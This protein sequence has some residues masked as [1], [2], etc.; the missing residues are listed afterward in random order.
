MQQRI[1]TAKVEWKRFSG[2]VSDL[3][4]R[5]G[6]AAAGKHVALMAGAHITLPV[7]ARRRS[8]ERF[9][10]AG[11]SLPYEF[12]RYNNSFLNERSVEIP[13]ARWFLAQVEAGRVLE[14]GNVLSHYGVRGHDV[15][16]R[17]ETIEGVMNYDIV[18]YTPDVPYDATITISTL[19][20]VGWD[21][22]PRQPERV[23]GGF[24]AV[25][26]ATRPG[27]K[28]LVTMPM[29]CNPVM[30]EAIGSGR[31]QMP[32]QSGLVRLDKENHWVEV[33]VD[34]AL[35][36]QYDSPFPNGNGIYVGLD[37]GS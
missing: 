7:R 22:E 16:D 13:I 20:H 5:V 3:V 9:E 25:R 30:D 12:A 28:S 33:S 6:P 1:D 19:E 2:G 35:T 36:R 34:E 31:I 15:L 24:D 27:G 32:V 4:Q 21:E 8:S 37:L 26:R 29:G 18:E 14:V 23:I 17:Y 10:V 11:A